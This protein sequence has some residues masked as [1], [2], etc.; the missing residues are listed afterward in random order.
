M[1]ETKSQFSYD[2]KP[3]YSS[4]EQL[5]L[6]KQIREPQQNRGPFLWPSPHFLHTHEGILQLLLVI[7]FENVPQCYPQLEIFLLNIWW[8]SD[9]FKVSQWKKKLQFKLRKERSQL[10][11]FLKLSKRIPLSIQFANFKLVLCFGSLQTILQ[12]HLK[13]DFEDILTLICFDITISVLKHIILCF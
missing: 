9:N 5:C 8:T 10:C 2:T 1:V 6:N 7:L 4:G 13:H 3:R 12:L 11:D